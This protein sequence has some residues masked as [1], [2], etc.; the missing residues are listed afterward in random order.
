L[1]GPGESIVIPPGTSDVH[2]E[3]EMV[4]VI[5]KRA[6]NVPVE[7]ALGYVLGV[8]C[9]NDVS[10]RDW[11][12]GDRQWWRAKGCDTFGPCG[13]CIVT[14]LNYDNLRVQMTQWQGHADQSTRTSSTTSPRVSFTRPRH[15]QPGDL[16]CT[17]T[18]ARRPRQ[19]AML[20]VDIEAWG[21]EDASS[22]SD[23]ANGSDAGHPASWPGA[24]D[25]GCDISSG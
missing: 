9:G 20:R 11:Q 14:G 3:A 8:T 19:G 5:G 23:G 22:P 7:R 24:D 4:I 6:R 25:P 18:R 21:A 16:I 1:I 12:K 17:G 10:A 13:P 2:Y 15:A